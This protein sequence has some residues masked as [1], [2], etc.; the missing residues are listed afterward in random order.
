M[1][2]LLT[3]YLSGIELGEPQ[4]F[5]NLVVVP[6]FTSRNGGPEYLTLGEALSGQLAA[7]TELHSAG[8]VPQVKV[9]NLAEGL[10]LLV[11]GEELIG[12]RQNRTLNTS[13]L[14]AGRTELVVPVSCTE[15]GRWAYKSL[16][17]ADAGFVSPHRLRKT[18]SDSVSASLL[19][20]LG[21]KSDQHAVWMAVDG[22]C[23][24]SGTKSP[25]RAMSDA[26]VTKA[27]E[28]ESYLKDLKP[29][30]GQK[31]LVA[32][33]NG[34]VAGMDVLS[35][36][37]A[38]QLLHGRLMRCYAMDALLDEGPAA[39]EAPRDQVRAFFE[40]SKGSKETVRQA[41]GCGQDHRFRGPSVAGAA[42]VAAG[43]VIHLSLYRN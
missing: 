3:E 35:S 31:G 20:N 15:A 37:R 22:L 30:E 38:Y 29:L 12:A 6:I 24:G 39:A 27:K 21:H 26:M 32:L 36:G 18:K 17:F 41:V 43:S 14:V 4:Q 5:R 40:A 34:K 13:I 25:T 10:L 1:N 33:V 9:T 28:L 7:I 16:A 42:L 19:R 8:S 11:D 23:A 2:T